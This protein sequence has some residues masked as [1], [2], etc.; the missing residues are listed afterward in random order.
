MRSMATTQLQLTAQGPPIPPRVGRFPQL[1]LMGSKHRLL[2]WLHE[3]FSA[4]SFDR[5]LDAFSG[6]GCV[7]YLLK[8]MGKE[9]VSNDFLRFPGVITAATV[10]NSTVKLTSGD[11]ERLIAPGPHDDF[12]ERT[13][14]G[15]FFNAAD[16]RF[17]DLV[18]ANIERLADRYARSVALA[19]LVRACVKRQPRGVFTVVSTPGRY[20]DGRR[21]LRLSLEQ[22]FREQ[23]DVFNACVFDSGR[24]HHA[25]TGDVFDVDAAGFDLVYLDPPY[26]PRSD[27]NCYVKRYHFIEGLVS[28][29]RGMEIMYNTRVRK[30][31]K[32]FTPFSYRRTALEAFAAL[33]ARFRKSTIVLSYSSNGY[34]DLADLVALMRSHKT[35]VDVHRR[36]HR[37]HFGTHAAVKRA[38]VEE[39]LVVGR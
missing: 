33:F 31:A 2:P 6:S 23:V 11:V 27:D 8:V 10:E 35:R 15:V 7:S 22:H 37:Y 14:A 24:R 18:H 39:Y 9:V 1:R 5:S 21:D 32:P 34:P 12:V 36:A 25:R 29:W 38:A 3:V 30:I 26:V 19:A 17:L 20:D 13:F 4:L 28:Y 16:L